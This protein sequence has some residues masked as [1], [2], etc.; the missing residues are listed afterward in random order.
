M[1][2]V[3]VAVGPA[4]SSLPGGDRIAAAPPI[5]EVGK[6][7]APPEDRRLAPATE[8]PRLR[9]DSGLSL[10]APSQMPGDGDPLRCDP[11]M[12]PPAVRGTALLI[13]RHGDG[14]SSLPTKYLRRNP[15]AD[16][17]DQDEGRPVHQIPP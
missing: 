4:K 6:A 10:R 3:I 9:G 15:C 14:V 11:G 12:A 5:A 13:T 17:E 1:S 16:A 2:T 8:L 7:G